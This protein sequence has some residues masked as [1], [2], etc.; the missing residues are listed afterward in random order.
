MPASLNPSAFWYPFLKK[1]IIELQ[2]ALETRNKDNQEYKSTGHKLL[3][4]RNSANLGKHNAIFALLLPLFPS[5]SFIG[6]CH[7][8]DSVLGGFGA[9]AEC[10]FLRS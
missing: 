8:K 4:S 6:Q 9:A 5:K 10:L 3:V 2:R 7:R 1:R